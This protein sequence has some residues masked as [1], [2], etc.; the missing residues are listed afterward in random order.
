[1][2]AL[3]HSCPSC[4]LFHRAPPVRR[5]RKPKPVRRPEDDLSREVFRATSWLRFWHDAGCPR[6]RAT[7][8]MLK[9]GDGLVPADL[10]V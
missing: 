8:Y 9:F 7:G 10:P 6:W 3:Y 5:L 2:R 4:G 1:M